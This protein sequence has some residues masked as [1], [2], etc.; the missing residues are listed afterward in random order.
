MQ[1]NILIKKHI[2]IEHKHIQLQLKV[3]KLFGYVLR[4]TR[5]NKYQHL[6]YKN[7]NITDSV[8]ISYFNYL[9]FGEQHFS[10]LNSQQPTT[11]CYDVFL[12]FFS[13][14]LTSN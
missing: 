6:F 10:T 12:N 8:E 5:D 3:I 7:K 4:D 9:W 1:Y 14:D 13:I 11:K 2:L